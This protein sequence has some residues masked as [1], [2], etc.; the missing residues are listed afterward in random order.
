[1]THFPTSS[2]EGTVRNSDRLATP[3]VV[4]TLLVIGGLLVGGTV[5]AVTYLTAR[6]IDPEPVFKL[7]GLAVTACA[8]L[9]GFVLQLV[10]RV[11]IAKTEQ[12]AGLAN[13]AVRQQT[14]HLQTL[15]SAV[16]DVSDALPRPVRGY[17][18]TL[19]QRTAPA[20]PGR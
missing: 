15:T 13:A 18:D 6:G 14:D 4:I 12:Q 7:A 5:A 9:G 11:T 2:K 20:P 1:V 3:A 17:E 19:L 8:S 10:N 16:Y